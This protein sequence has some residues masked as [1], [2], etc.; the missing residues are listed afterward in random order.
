M[1]DVGMYLLNTVALGIQAEEDDEYIELGEDNSQSVVHLKFRTCEDVGLM[2]KL[3]PTGLGKHSDLNSDGRLTFLE[4]YSNGCITVKIVLPNKGLFCAEVFGCNRS[5]QKESN[6]W[7]YT[8][9]LSYF[10]DNFRA[11]SDSAM[12]GYPVVNPISASKVEF[13]LLRWKV[14][15]E[16]HVAV[17][18]TGEADL[19]FQ[20]HKN[21]KVQPTLT[22]SSG[23]SLYHYTSLQQVSAVNNMSQYTLK[24]VFPEKGHWTITLFEVESRNVLMK[25]HVHC[26]KPLFGYSYPKI[27]SD[28]IQLPHYKTPALIKGVLSVPFRTTKTLFFKGFIGLHS[29]ADYNDIT[30]DQAYVSKEGVRK[31]QLNVV[32]PHV[33]MWE[34][35]VLL[36]DPI[37][38][39]EISLSEAFSIL[40]EVVTESECCPQSV[41]PQL[42][43]AA[44]NFRIKIPK[45][46]VT[47][48]LS[49]QVPISIKVFTPSN[50]I[51]NHHIEL[52]ENSTALDK[53]TF[54]LLSDDAAVPSVLKAVFPEPGQWIVKLFA[55]V[56]CKKAL[57]EVLSLCVE[58][59]DSPYTNF[60]GYPEILPI[61]AQQA[62]FR[63]LDWSSSQSDHIAETSTGTLKVSFTTKQGVELN[64]FIVRGKDEQN[65]IERIDD[66]STLSPP[67]LQ[68]S[69]CQ[70]Q[71]LTVVFPDKG[72]W[73]VYLLEEKSFLMKYTVLYPNTL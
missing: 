47:S 34:V 56:D 30:Y 33:G 11:S 31:Y 4:Y 62:D 69:K 52:A 18:N 41:Y 44:S 43:R 27:S 25:Y 50:L 39:G 9:F 63:L 40:T 23:R 60:C 57:K 24:V 48:K 29:R 58:V 7:T 21:V 71:F 46:P 17:S 64:H 26:S 65:T 54:L 6:D 8:R 53:C 22:H 35:G 13:R 16:E 36:G 3:L 19:E 20:L 14:S 51:F 28:I 15:A 59:V 37:A 42:K 45:T 10:I 72:Y 12:A 2:V 55:E 49:A 66:S 73:T 70:K 61:A 67:I 68:L 1:C 32:L 5:E 38:D